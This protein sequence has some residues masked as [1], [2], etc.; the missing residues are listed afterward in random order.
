MYFRVEPA[1]TR[2]PE[3]FFFLLCACTKNK[4]STCVLQKRYTV[5]KRGLKLQINCNHSWLVMVIG[6]LKI[7]WFTGI[8]AV[9]KE[10]EPFHEHFINYFLMFFYV[11]ISVTWKSKSLS[12][13][14]A[15][16]QLMIID[17]NCTSNHKSY[18]WSPFKLLYFGFL[19]LQCTCFWVKFGLL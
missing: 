13:I 11:V 18:Y 6:P 12:T 3:T 10:A 4:K 7:N 1:S 15:T 17:I 5:V 16:F 8:Y 2:Q 19:F 9:K 14:A